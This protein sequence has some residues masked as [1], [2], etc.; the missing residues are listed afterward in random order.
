MD[1]DFGEASK[2][3]TLG[4]IGP[5]TNLRHRMPGRL[6]AAASEAQ[7]HTEKAAVFYYSKV[8]LRL[9]TPPPARQHVPAE[10]HAATS[11]RHIYSAMSRRALAR[12]QQRSEEQ[13]TRNAN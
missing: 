1:E 12:Q 10:C 11:W 4:V 13:G 2:G 5:R 8:K 7:Q 3:F 6:T 9:S